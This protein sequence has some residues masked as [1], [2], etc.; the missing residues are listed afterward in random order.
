MAKSKKNKD[1]NHSDPFGLMNEAVV[2]VTID[3]KQVQPRP[4]LGSFVG[5][6]WDM[7]SEWIMSNRTGY[8]SVIIISLE[9]EHK[10]HMYFT[11]R[12]IGDHIAMDFLCYG[13]CNQK[14][15]KIFGMRIIASRDVSE[16]E[17]IIK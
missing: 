3:R 1:L 5:R 13:N 8:P 14:K 12:P 10:M 6:I 9:L 4:E 11:S 15:R 16:D 2:C 7:R 17:I